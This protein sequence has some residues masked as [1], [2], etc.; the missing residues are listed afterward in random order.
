MQF[1]SHEKELRIDVNSDTETALKQPKGFLARFLNQQVPDAYTILGFQIDNLT[2]EQALQRLVELAKHKTNAYV[3]LS[4]VHMVVE[5]LLNKKFNAIVSNATLRLAD[6]MPLC[7]ATRLIYSEKLERIAGMDLLPAILHVAEQESLSIYFLGSQEHIMQK[8]FERLHQEHPRLKVAGYNT[9]MVSCELEKNQALIE[10]INTSGADIVCVCLGCPKQETWMSISS[11]FIP[12][13]MLGLGAAFAVYAGELSRAPLW[14]QKASLEWLHRLIQDPVRLWKRYFVT[15][16][17]FLGLIF[18]QFL[19]HHT[20][21]SFL[22]RNFLIK[23][24]NTS[25]SD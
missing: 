4:N 10:E 1:L 25:V 19:C 8:F 9:A 24:S 7:H 5:S 6:G 20:M 12:A 17:I 15:N 13:V 22:V 18:V 11:P 16:S 2:F 3:T 21:K 14:M 23:G